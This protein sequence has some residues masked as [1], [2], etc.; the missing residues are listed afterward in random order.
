MKKKI[1]MFYLLTTFVLSFSAWADDMQLSVTGFEEN[2]MP[3][4]VRPEAANGNWRFIA[5]TG[6]AYIP[7]YEGASAYSARPIPLFEASNGNF[8]ASILSGIGYHF[9]KSRTFQFGARI[10]GAP[11]RKESVDPRLAG[12]GD[13][14]TSGEVG[15]FLKAKFDHIYFTSK[16]SG[17]R[18]GSRAELGGG[19]DFTASEADSLRLGIAANWASASYMQTYF[20]VTTEQAVTSSLAAYDAA[21]GIRSYGLVTSWTHVFN[22]EWLSNLSLS[23][24]RLAGSAINSPLVQTESSYSA[25]YVVLYLF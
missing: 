15:L 7:H 21:G 3:E 14:H 25:S 6:P 1:W 8:F 17:G 9:V 22:R 12:M 16:V 10:A 5:G 24:K 2:S 23:A 20:G 11:G 4:F 18:R 13:L 19:F